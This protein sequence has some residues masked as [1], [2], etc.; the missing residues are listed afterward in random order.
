MST[1]VQLRRDAAA[2]VAAF[3]GAQGEVVVDTTN[4][5]LVVQDGATPA[6][7]RRRNCRRCSRSAPRPCSRKRRMAAA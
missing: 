7:S 5:R 6:A 1:Q 2:N 3:I 4:N